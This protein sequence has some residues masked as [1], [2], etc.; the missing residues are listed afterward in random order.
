MTKILF[1]YCPKFH[2][3][4]KI[5]KKNQLKLRNANNEIFKQKLI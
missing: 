3:T 4:N 5:E 1:L 2:F